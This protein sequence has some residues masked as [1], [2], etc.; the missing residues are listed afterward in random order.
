MRSLLFMIRI[1]G[2]RVSVSETR[3]KTEPCLWRFR[4]PIGCISSGSV[5]QLARKG[6]SN[7]ASQQFSYPCSLGNPDGFRQL[8][9]KSASIGSLLMCR[10]RNV[11]CARRW[12]G[13]KAHGKL[14]QL[15][16][17][18]GSSRDRA[19][20]FSELGRHC[21]GQEAD[22]GTPGYGPLSTTLNLLF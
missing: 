6:I 10:R 22:R 18:N 9:E 7:V 8:L 11:R 19:R 12:P 2:S 21:T 17:F 5:S 1:A 14:E 4:Y 16:R 15:R 13:N 20:L 3:S